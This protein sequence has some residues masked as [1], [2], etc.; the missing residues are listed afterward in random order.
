M[1][2]SLGTGRTPTKSNNEAKI[3]RDRREK[4]MAEDYGKRQLRRGYIG[5]PI[6]RVSQ[7]GHCPIQH[8]LPLTLRDDELG[9]R[10]KT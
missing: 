10:K 5:D 1:A 2:G 3:I 9:F 4:I 7:V 6:T 8:K